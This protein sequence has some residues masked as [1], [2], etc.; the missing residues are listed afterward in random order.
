MNPSRLHV[1]RF[2]VIII[3]LLAFWFQCAAAQTPTATSASELRIVSGKILGVSKTGQ[4]LPATVSNVVEIL[5]ENYREATIA[6]VGVD[7]VLIDNITL[8]IAPRTAGRGSA[9][10]IALAALVE[11]SG[12]KFRL[13]D[14]SDQDF[15]LS[16]DRSPMGRRT[17][18]V[19]NLSQI[20][21]N[22]QGKQ[23][24]RQIRETETALAAVRKVMTNDHP[25]VADMST[26]LEIL[27]ATKAQAA[28]PL[29][30]T[31]VIEQ[32][33]DTVAATLGLLKSAEKQPE[34][35]FHPGANL[36]IV[37]GGDEAIEITRK[38]VAAL[39]K[40]SN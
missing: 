29:D 4:P 2:A 20:L 38:V 3:A 11:A 18:E 17:A 23:L 16:A 14:F 31:K 19:F 7:D 27:K 1:R 8:R 10:R 22:N 30:S 39:E 33:M 36:L 21:S 9:L 28:A 24:E 6:V 34:F 13:Q 25:R 35:Q 5:R 26:Q 12:R 40:G 15:M 32:I 37:V